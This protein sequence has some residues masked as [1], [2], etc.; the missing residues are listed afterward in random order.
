MLVRTGG[1]GLDDSVLLVL[2]HP[3]LVSRGVGQDVDEVA[4]ALRRRVRADG[5]QPML[6]AVYNL[7][8]HVLNRQAFVPNQT[9]LLYIGS[10][11]SFILG[12][13]QR[14]IFVI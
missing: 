6:A 3:E 13:L 1:N 10:N 12:R 9:N 8:D 7:A 11:S 2:E 5:R 4:L 14:W